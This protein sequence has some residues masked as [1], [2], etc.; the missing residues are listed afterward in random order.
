M[1][2]RNTV[3]NHVARIYGKI[4]VNKRGAAIVWARERGLASSIAKPPRKS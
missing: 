2:T 1:M 4:G 3:R